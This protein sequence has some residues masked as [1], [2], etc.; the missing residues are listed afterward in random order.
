MSAA[1]VREKDEDARAVFTTP[2]PRSHTLYHR[3]T[4]IPVYHRR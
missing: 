4:T 3:Y 1:D 2:T